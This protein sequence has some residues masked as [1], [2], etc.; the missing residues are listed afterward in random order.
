MSEGH[1]LKQVSPPDSITREGAT[2]GQQAG[3]CWDTAESPS[4]AWGAKA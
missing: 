1:G 3:T 4:P 2:Q